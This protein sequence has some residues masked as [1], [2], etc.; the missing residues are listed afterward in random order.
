MCVIGLYQ[1]RHAHGDR[2]RFLWVDGESLQARHG[3]AAVR[4]ALQMEGSA[5]G[6]G[7][8]ATQYGVLAASVDVSRH[9]RSDYDE[10]EL[11]AT[12]RK[13]GLE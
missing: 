5:A 13:V 11:D 8:S 3:I 10:A 9:S 6:G 1:S 4:L 2:A 7:P 12:L